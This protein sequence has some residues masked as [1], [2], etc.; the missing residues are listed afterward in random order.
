[1]L[2]V[3][4]SRED[5]EFINKNAPAFK[6]EYEGNPPIIEDT[7]VLFPVVDEAGVSHF[8]SALNFTIVH[9]GLIN[10]DIVNKIGIRLY[11]I[12]DQFELVED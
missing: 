3:E 5:Y 10:Q 7:R 12:Y 2:Y 8:E 1:M 11:E 6:I 4:L 9:D